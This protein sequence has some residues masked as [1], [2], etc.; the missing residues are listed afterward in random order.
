MKMEKSSLG[1][2]GIGQMGLPMAKN[3][4]AAG[5]A[6]NVYARKKSAADPLLSLGASLVDSPAQLSESCEIVI[7]ALPA[8][9]DVK[10]IIF[11]KE[12]LAEKKGGLRTIIDTSTID[13]NSSRDISSRLEKIGID[14]LDAPVSGGPEGATNATLTFMVGGKEEAF[15]RNEELLGILGKNI[16]YLGASGS[17]TGAK[18]V[19]QLLVSSNTLASA[20]AMQLCMAL[21]IDP[22]EV[23]NVIKTSAGDSFAFRRVAPI[24]ASGNYGPGWQTRLLEEDLKLLAATE[25]ELG[26]PAISVRLSLEIFSESVK[27]GN[28]NVD[29]SSVIKVLEKMRAT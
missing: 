11:G 23:I 29:S 25:R 8:P 26:L 9:S 1:Q 18:L 4:L 20:E 21:Q 6:L 24:I 5:L 13:P 22:N 14:Y 16:F 2:I 28:G 27:M 17:G 3:L 19:N 12:G 7:L 10:E 15:K